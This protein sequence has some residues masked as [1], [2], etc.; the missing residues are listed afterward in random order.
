MNLISAEGMVLRDDFHNFLRNGI[1]IICV[2]FSTSGFYSF[3][4]AAIFRMIFSM[5]EDIAFIWIGGP[6]F[7]LFSILSFI[8]LPRVL[9]KAKIID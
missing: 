5:K 1:V 2:S 4:I 3:V 6:C 9:R 7:F 8:F